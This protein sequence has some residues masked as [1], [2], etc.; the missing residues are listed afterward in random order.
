MLSSKA[1]GNSMI[2]PVTVSRSQEADI[3]RSPKMIYP[4]SFPL[5]ANLLC[6]KALVLELLG[7]VFAD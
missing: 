5:L 7:D 6:L 4:Y 1:P 3:C 2:N